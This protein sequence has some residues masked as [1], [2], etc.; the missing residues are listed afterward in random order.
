[1]HRSCFFLFVLTLLVLTQGCA[2]KRE[3]TAMS[4]ETQLEQQPLDSQIADFIGNNYEGATQ[5]FM[6]TQYGTATVTVGRSYYSALDMPCKEAYLQ[7]SRRT[8]VAA[9]HDSK[10]GWVLAPDILGDGAL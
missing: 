1:M 4:H 8:R 6:N 9:C 10:K 7:G 3:T 5:T 2:A